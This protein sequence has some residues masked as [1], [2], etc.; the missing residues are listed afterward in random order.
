M[1][2][3]ISLSDKLIIEPENLT[4]LFAIK[5]FLENY[6]NETLNDKI[7]IDDEVIYGRL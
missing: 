1:R 7:V 4:E 3:E 6:N 5:S 2:S